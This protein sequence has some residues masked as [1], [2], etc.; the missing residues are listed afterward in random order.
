MISCLHTA[1]VHVET[2]GALIADARHVVREDLLARA[3]SE[4]T[5]AVRDEVVKALNEIA[6]DGPVL[7]T[8][9]T[10]GPLVDELG[11]SQIVR[12]DRPAMELAVAGGGEVVVAICLESTREATL[13]LFDQVASGR[14]TAKLVLCDQAWPY[15]EAGDMEAFAAEI[16]KAVTGQGSRVLLA[17]ASMAVAA[18]RLRDVGLEVFTTPQA[19]AAAVTALP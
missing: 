6:K 10:L 4:G 2:F 14:A 17:Q 12:I 7:C 16:Q 13:A 8:C 19:A 3:R 18:G 15:F 9:S 5:D 11:D 1:Q